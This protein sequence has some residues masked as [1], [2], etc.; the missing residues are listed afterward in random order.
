MVDNGEGKL[1]FK[2]KCPTNDEDFSK[3]DNAFVLIDKIRDGEVSLNE[4]KDDEA[5]LNSTLAEIRKVPKNIY[6]KKI[7]KQRQMLKTFVMQE[8]QLFIFLMN[9]LQ[10]HLKLGAKDFQ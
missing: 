4:A 5:K 1:V 8:E 10:E 2:Y 9:I 7:R 6:Q 3:F